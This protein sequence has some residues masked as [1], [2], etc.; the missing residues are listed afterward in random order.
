[1]N[2]M[3]ELHAAG[4]H[5]LLL[6]SFNTKERVRIRDSISSVTDG[7]S[8]VSEASSW[9]NTQCVK[10]GAVGHG[11][12]RQQSSLEG[13]GRWQVTGEMMSGWLMGNRQRATPPP[14][15]FDKNKL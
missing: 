5:V 8:Y 2:I 3:V 12:G 15:S 13:K 7:E 10:H 6:S 11:R 1:M 14:S 9:T 4:L